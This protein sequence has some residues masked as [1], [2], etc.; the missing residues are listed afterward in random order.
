MFSRR[1]W[2]WGLLFIMGGMLGLSTAVS[3]PPS[4]AATTY[5][6]Y[7]PL[8]SRALP[9]PTIPLPEPLPPPLI[10]QGD[11]VIDFTAVGEDLSRRNLLLAT[12][13]IGFHVGMGG[14]LEGLSDWMR[15]LDAAGV[16]II[17]KSADN[18]GPLYEAQQLAQQSGVPHILIYRRTGP[19]YDVP[20]Y[21]L[22]P[23]EAAR[24]HWARHTAVFP[25]E[26][27]K[28]LVWLET[29]NEVDKNRADWLA[30]FA[31]ETARLA[32]RDG[33]KWAAFGWSGGEPEPWQ[34]RTPKMRQF[35]HFVGQY[36]DQL[37]I[38]LHE[39]SFTTHQVGVG[40][41]YLVG[42]FQ[43]LF[44]ACDDYG[45]NRPT[46][47]ITEWGWEYQNVPEPSRALADI[48]WAA[49][50][51]AAYPEVK[52]AAIWYL[53]GWFG[54]IHHQT[55]KLIRPVTDYS[56]RT[57]FIVT[58]GRGRIDT[59]LFV[60]PLADPLTTQAW[61]EQARMRRLGKDAYRE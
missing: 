25:P 45:L 23:R 26:L 7:L 15:E 51:Y 56:L 35:L 48:H 12:N 42:R 16:P 20:N 6:I 28:N 9:P 50:L 38:A 24:Q 8:I 29:I 59:G 53:G 19:E 37:A 10:V 39:Y 18:A 33:Y 1:V 55:Q 5:Q 44:Q 30:D 43:L 47:F 52:G 34:W 41:P 4:H 21:S 32:L 17:L 57:Y 40:Y 3:S 27:D 60:P 54:E 14:N 49:N 31:L 46:V 13:K 58:P 2:L 61:A 22:P 11:E 36:P